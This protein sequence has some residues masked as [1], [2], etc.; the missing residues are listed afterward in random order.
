[1]ERFAFVLIFAATSTTSC[2]PEGPT[3]PLPPGTPVAANGDVGAVLAIASRDLACPAAGVRVVQTY[4]R[5]F[6]NGT[7]L[8]YLV[9]GCGERALYGE[10]CGTSEC[11][12]V[13]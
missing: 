13:L 9:E 12:Y 5:R 3:E 8:R 10:T 7:D 11:A 4:D 6:L 1:M 2:M